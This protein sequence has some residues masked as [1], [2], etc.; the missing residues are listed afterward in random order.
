[1]KQESLLSKEFVTINA[2]SFLAY[3]NMAV[4][5]QLHQYLLTLPIDPR[6]AGFLIGV[7]SLAGVFMQ[8]LLSPFIK[9]RNAGRTIVTGVCMT[10]AALLLY[11]WADSFPALLVLRIFH[12]VGFITF[13]TGMNAIMVSFIPASKSG[14]AFGIVSVSLL[15]PQ[16]VVPALLGWMGLGPAHFVDILS[17][18][19]VLMVPTAVVTLFVL[20]KRRPEKPGTHH[21]ETDT[22][23][24]LKENLR[25]TRIRA[26]LFTNFLNFLAYTPVFFFI[27]EYAEGKG[28]ANPGSFFSVA[29]GAMIVIRLLG[30]VLFDRLEKGRMLVVSLGLLSIGYTLLILVTPGLFLIL[31]FILGVAWS[32]FMP[33]LNALL[34]D[35]SRPSARALNLNLSMALLQSGY[36]VGPIIGGLILHEAGYG[37]VFLYCG[38]M[39]FIGACLNLAFLKSYKRGRIG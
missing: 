25:D 9:P 29:T 26:L 39:T 19:A 1:M 34:F 33:F 11:R 12:G 6:F 27:K 8:P 38:S 2:A 22:W 36:F 37:A 13:V 32:L 31:A 3:I 16:A 35:C 30:G 23:R 14:Q 21:T 20:K 17:V 10:I 18:T 24:E 4:F 15:L 28:I 5:F 7:F